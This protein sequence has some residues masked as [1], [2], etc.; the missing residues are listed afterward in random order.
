MQKSTVC[1]C[2]IAMSQCHSVSSLDSVP[3]CWR[4]SC[5]GSEVVAPSFSPTAKLSPVFLLLGMHPQIYGVYPKLILK[6]DEVQFCL[7][8]SPD[9][10]WRRDTEQICY[11]LWA[12]ISLLK[13]D[14]ISVL[15]NTSF[16]GGPIK[17]GVGEG[18]N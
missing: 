18:V 2:K 1:K 4:V 6:R 17:R 11:L 12:T 14:G 7:R 10:L 16:W 5:N 3:H 13:H 9:G 15:L 8:M